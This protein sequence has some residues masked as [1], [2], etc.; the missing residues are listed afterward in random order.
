M[1]LNP[2]ETFKISIYSP[3]HTNNT[4]IHVELFKIY[5]KRKIIFS[6]NLSS[7]KLALYAIIYCIIYIL[8]GH[9]A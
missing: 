3:K 7:N 6:K 5:K 1:N 8:E 2:I 4:K 9:T